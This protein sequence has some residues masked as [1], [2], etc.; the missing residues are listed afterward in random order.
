MKSV[1]INN[2][3]TKNLQKHIEILGLGR[4]KLLSNKLISAELK[5]QSAWKS[6]HREMEFDSYGCQE[7]IQF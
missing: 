1:V 5:T 7:K 3:I 2:L 4:L 6:Q